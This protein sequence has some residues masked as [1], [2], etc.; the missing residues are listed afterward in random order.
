MMR[1]RMCND[2][3]VN[4]DDNED[5]DEDGCVD[6]N[7]EAI[8]RDHEMTMIVDIISTTIGMAMVIYA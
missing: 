5:E 6:I 4:N 7:D 8:N 2:N 3:D 1:M